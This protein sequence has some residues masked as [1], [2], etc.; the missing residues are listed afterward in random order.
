MLQIFKDVKFTKMQ[1]TVIYVKR[2]TIYKQVNA[3]P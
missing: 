2:D 1:K 3:H